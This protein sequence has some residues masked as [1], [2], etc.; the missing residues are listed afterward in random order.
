M[1]TVKEPQSKR[2]TPFRIA[3]NPLK[4]QLWYLVVP[5]DTVEPSV[6]R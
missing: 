6:I 3:A 2:I 4:R 5:P 1:S